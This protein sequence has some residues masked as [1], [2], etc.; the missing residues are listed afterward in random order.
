[1]IAALA[2][3]YFGEFA[4][5][6]EVLVTR[7]DPRPSIPACALLER[8][9]LDSVLRRF[10]PPHA[11]GD[12]R[13]LAS[14]WSK[15]YLVRL[16]PPVV[17]AALVLGRTLPLGFDEVEVVLD[18]QGIPEAFKLPGEGGPFAAPPGDPFQRFAHLLEGHLQPFIHT[19]ATEARLSP[20]VLW[21]NAG[22]YFE[23]FIGEMAKLPPLASMLG[24]G[25]ELLETERRPDGM[26]NP[27]FKPIQY[28]EVSC[29][30]RA[31]GL[32]RQRRT[33]CI[34]YRLGTIGHCDNCPLIDEPPP[35]VSDL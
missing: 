4:S 1:M 22:N 6:R 26:R 18:A 21:S 23:W 33:C 5:Y 32:W 7:D 2:P 31:N 24:H 29:E 17:A 20:R 3:L 34:R 12:R 25:R 8:E 35:E 10:D 30:Q 19:L 13:A 11:D 9:M 27:L 15:W 14:Q 16:I 28:V